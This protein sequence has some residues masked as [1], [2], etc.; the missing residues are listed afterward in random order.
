MIKRVLLLTM[1]LLPVSSVNATTINREDKMLE[2]SEEEI[3]LMERLTMSEAGVEPYECKVATLVTVLKRAKMYDKSIAEVI[4]EP[5][6]YS[7]ANNGKPTAEVK[8]AVIEAVEKE[9]EY[10][11]N[12]I[13]FRADYY[14]PFGTPYMSVGNHYFSLN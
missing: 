2:Y 14:H 11:D 6:Q 10:P 7:L 1:L 8:E 13:Y 5:W 3:A 12:M 9:E 4:Y